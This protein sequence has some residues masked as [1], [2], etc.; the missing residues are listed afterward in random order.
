MN[1]N[2]KKNIVSIIL[3]VAVI[4]LLIFSGPARAIDVTLITQNID[5]SSQAK[6]ITFT[7]NVKVN[8]GEFL[9]ISYTNLTFD[10]GENKLICKIQDKNSDCDFLTVQNINID[11]SLEYKQDYG[12]GYG[13]GSDNTQG[14]QNFGYGYGYGY[15]TETETGVITYTL[16]IDQTKLPGSFVGQN[17]DVEARVYGAGD[18]ANFRGSSSFKVNSTEQTIPWD[19]STEKEQDFGSSKVTISTNALPAG[20]TGIKVQQITKNTV[21]APT[22]ATLKV[23]SKIFEFQIDGTTE[24]NFNEPVTLTITYTDEELALAGITDESKISPYFFDVVSNDW[25][26]AG[27]TDIVRDP[28][29]NK[30]EFKVSHFTKFTLL[31]DTSTPSTATTTTTSGATGGGA[32]GTRE[33][34]TPAT[35]LEETPT[36]ITP[37]ETATTTTPAAPAGGLGAITGAVIGAVKNNSTTL[38]IIVS[39]VVVILVL[40]RVPIRNPFGKGKGKNYQPR[41]GYF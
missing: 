10:D 17:I 26:N 4:S 23:L 25:T 32:G 8:N 7:I 37:V 19:D 20:A 22:T 34:V 1:T 36:E 29:N 15:G 6:D 14:W 18:R 16:G 30:I 35:T 3:T 21:A 9:P 2:A 27:I 13:Y 41:A 39:V 38:I 31:A 28:A 12:Y 40:T 24:T 33:G 5:V 11:P